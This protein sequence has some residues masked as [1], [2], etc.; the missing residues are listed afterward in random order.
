[1]KDSINGATLANE[2]RMRRS[3]FKGAFL[4]VEGDSDERLY[5]IFTNHEKCQIIICHG[6]ANSFDA[7]RNLREAGTLGILAIAD[8]DFEH[9]EGRNPP[10]DC[11]LFTDWHDAECMMLRGSAFERVVSQFISREKFATWS[12]DH[13]SDVRQYL[14]NQSVSVGYLLWHSIAGGLGLDF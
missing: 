9:L 5:G 7:C 14:L 12:E 6:R 10:V 2:A 4:F 13:G 3:V 11:V 8:A 1:M